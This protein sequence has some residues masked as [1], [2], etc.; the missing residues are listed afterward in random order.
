MSSTLIRLCAAGLLA[1]LC[2]GAPALAFDASNIVKVQAGGGD[3]QGVNEEAARRNRRFDNRFDFRSDWRDRRD[4]DRNDWAAPAA[5]FV[6]GVL[7]GGALANSA[8]PPAPAPYM[9]P[10]PPYAAAPY[11]SNPHV[12]W[13]LANHPGYNPYDNTYEAYYGGPRYACQSPYGG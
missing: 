10:I 3:N 9:A 2:S 1:A 12:D 6:G 7:L 4:R 8:P 13:C 5:G 11:G